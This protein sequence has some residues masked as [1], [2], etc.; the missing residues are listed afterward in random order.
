M[1]SSQI[2]RILGGACRAR[3]GDPL[4]RRQAAAGE[5]VGV[6]E[7]SSTPSRSRSSWS[8]IGD[9]L[10]QDQA[11][12]GEQPVAGHRKKV[13]KYCQP[14]ASIISIDTEP[15]VGAAQVAV[16]LAAASATRSSSPA[17]RTRCVASAC[18]AR[19]IVVVV[20]RQP[21]SRARVHR[22][23]APAGADLQ[24]VVA[25]DGALQPLARSVSSFC[26]LRLL[27][28]RVLRGK[29]AHE[30]IIRRSRNEEKRSLP[31]S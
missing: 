29:Y 26:Q 21:W 30:Y 9:R 5:D 20:T 6:G 22:Q 25:R 23:P 8:S 15:V 28:A 17:S 11:V 13:S 16:V 2:S 12:G 7:S 4:R 27:E 14:T 18:C 24:Q 10:Q 19:E 31:R 1:S 3:V